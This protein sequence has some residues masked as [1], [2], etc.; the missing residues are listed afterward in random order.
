MGEEPMAATDGAEEVVDTVAVDVSVVGTSGIAPA[1]GEDFPGVAVEVTV[2]EGWSD[3]MEG[4]GVAHHVCGF[5]VSGIIPEVGVSCDSTLAPVGTMVDGC[6]IL[7]ARGDS[8]PMSAKSIVTG[9]ISLAITIDVS[10][11]GECTG[12]SAPSCTLIFVVEGAVSLVE[13]GP[14]PTGGVVTGHVDLAVSVDVS[15]L[16]V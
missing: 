14:M 1:S 11:G 15:I 4:T 9:L 6:A 16:G 2:S 12:M 8:G 10:V 3:E 7:H 13:S 5:G